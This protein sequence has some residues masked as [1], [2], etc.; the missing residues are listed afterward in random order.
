MSSWSP[1]FIRILSL[2]FRHS[3]RINMRIGIFFFIR[4]LL[5]LRHLSSFLM[6]D[7]YVPCS[8]LRVHLPFYYDGRHWCCC[9]HCHCRCC[10]F[11]ISPLNCV[12][13]SHHMMRIQVQNIGRIMIEWRTRAS[14]SWTTTI[15]MI[16]MW[17]VSF[18]VEPS[19]QTQFAKFK[20]VEWEKST[21]TNTQ[22]LRSIYFSASHTPHKRWFA[23]VCKCSWEWSSHS[24]K[25]TLMLYLSSGDLGTRRLH[26]TCNSK[27]LNMKNIPFPL[28]YLIFWNGIYIRLVCKILNNALSMFISTVEFFSFERWKKRRT[29]KKKAH[30][31]CSGCCCFGCYI[32]RLGIISRLLLFQAPEHSLRLPWVWLY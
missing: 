29:K 21:H 31:I 26:F 28:E 4:S 24:A 16:T 13:A 8:C 6:F 19:N 17:D 7:K 2:S 23:A 32:W 20:I 5:C 12:C 27:V 9:R 15:K 22:N 18:I 25:A 14:T 11:F 3:P 1:I 10:F 30:E